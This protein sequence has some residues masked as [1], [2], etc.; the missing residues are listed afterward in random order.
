MCN[1]RT[2]ITVK[3]LNDLSKPVCYF[4]ATVTNKTA[5]RSDRP[6][7][8]KLSDKNHTDCC[9]QTNGSYVRDNYVYRASTLQKNLHYAGARKHN[10]NNGDRSPTPTIYPFGMN[11]QGGFCD[12]A[13]LTLKQMAK[14]KFKHSF[15]TKRKLDWLKAQWVNETCRDLQAKVIKTAAFCHNRALQDLFPDSYRLL[16]ITGSFNSISSPFSN[17]PDV[18]RVQRDRLEG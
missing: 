7:S 15:A 1:K 3:S 6:K 13:V 8:I 12:F 17:E 18:Q 2:D 14:K 16:F 5:K 11:T 4:D 10:Y 9:P